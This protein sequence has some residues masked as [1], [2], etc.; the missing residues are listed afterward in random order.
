MRLRN[1]TLEK[2]LKQSQNII[3]KKSLENEN[4][5]TTLKEERKLSLAYALK[6]QN[7]GKLI[8]KAANFCKTNI[9]F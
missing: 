8:K 5:A 4:M 3:A 1:T 6:K 7:F 9:Q 2:E